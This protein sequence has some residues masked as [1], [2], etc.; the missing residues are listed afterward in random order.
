MDDPKYVFEKVGA[1]VLVRL[2]PGFVVYGRCNDASDYVLGIRAHI[3]LFDVV[4]S[5][6]RQRL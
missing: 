5:S 2:A 4:A 3:E 6:F 1:A